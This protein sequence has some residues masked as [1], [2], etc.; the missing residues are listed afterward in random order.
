MLVMEQDQIKEQ[1]EKK[2]A[3]SLPL[4]VATGGRS[5]LATIVGIAFVVLGSWG[6]IHWRQEFIYVLKGFVPFSL[7]LGGIVA[8][9]VGIA[10]LKP[11]AELQ[12]LVEEHES[13]KSS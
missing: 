7:F 11:S 9:F 12:K 8:A 2:E 4:P 1:R 5:M 6:M 10:S 3:S 13:K